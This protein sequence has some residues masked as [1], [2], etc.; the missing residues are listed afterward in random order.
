MDILVIGTGMYTTGLGTNEYGTIIPSIFEYQRQNNLVNNVF[1]VGSKGSNTK[2]AIKK[3]H[4][5]SKLTNIKIN[6]SFFPKNNIN[7]KSAY[8]KV[9]KKIKLPACAIIAVPDHL[10]FEITK[11]CLEKGLHTLVVKPLT[12]NIKQ[13]KKLIEITKKNKIYAAVEFHK[14]WDRQN[15]ML[16]DSFNKKELGIPLY[17]WTEYSQQKKIPENFFRSWA[18]KTNILQYLGTHYIDIIRFVTEAIPT[19]VM[20][21]GQKKWLKKRGINSYDSIQCIINWKMKNGN[22]FSQTLLTNWIDPNTSSAV[23]DQKIKFIGTKGRFESDQ[24][25][26]GISIQLDNQILQQPNPDFCKIYG[27]KKGNF[28][29]RGYGIDSIKAFLKDVNSIIN[30]PENLSLIKKNRP[31]FEESLISTSVIEA[32][33]KS[34]KN[35]SNWKKINF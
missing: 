21:I 14:R 6:F 24:K 35:N 7:D 17:T 32:A 28:Q 2:K 1:V 3:I 12:N 9:L 5:V 19:H 22:N 29:W 26:R 10:H 13:S 27:Y 4:K 33:N 20:A 34:L 30:F 31:T 16:K 11:D 15:L 18:H 23:S 8:K 25:D